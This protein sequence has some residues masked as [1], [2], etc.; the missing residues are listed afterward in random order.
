MIVA[1]HDLQGRKYR[2]SPSIYPPPPP[3]RGC[4]L[5]C[6]K[7]RK[8]N[9]AERSKWIP[10]SR[11]CFSWGR[12]THRERFSDP[13]ISCG[14]NFS[15]GSLALRIGAFDK[16]HVY[17]PVVIL[18]RGATIRPV[19]PPLSPFPSTFSFLY[20]HC[21]FIDTSHEV[22]WPPHVPVTSYP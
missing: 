22:D 5:W 11:L 6:R 3:P 18:S 4:D 21:H 15:H 13:D 14:S 17:G 16:L 8:L 1:P 12:C 10:P 2:V 9:D 7:W 19:P 20:S